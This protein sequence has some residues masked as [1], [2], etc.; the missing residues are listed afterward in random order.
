VDN[1]GKVLIFSEKAY[2]NMPA[3]PAGE[4]VGQGKTRVALMRKGVDMSVRKIAVIGIAEDQG[5]ACR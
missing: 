4:F 2:T 1:R 5:W 3:D